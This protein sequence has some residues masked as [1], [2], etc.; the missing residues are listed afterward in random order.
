MAEFEKTRK[1]DAL[2]PPYHLFRRD[3]ED[4]IFPYTLTHGIGVLIY[5]P[6]AHGLL[7]GKYS[8]GSAFPSNDWRS[9]S[10]MFG[11]DA[12]RRDVDIVTKLQDFAGSRELSLGQLAIAWTLANPAVDVSIVGA[13]R[14]RQIEQTAPAANIHLTTQDLAEIDAIM[15]DA[16][17]VGG[18]APE[19]M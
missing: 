14:P 16:V 12:L 19:A 2:Q 18:P 13:R 9:K 17:P 5:G 1:V 3:A 4:T 15:V 8:P 10:S 6:L 11:G 7:T